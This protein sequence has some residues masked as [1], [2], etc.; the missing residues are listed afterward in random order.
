[1]IY[2]DHVT[3]YRH[4]SL[5]YLDAPRT[6]PQRSAWDIAS[7]LTVTIAGAALV[8]VAVMILGAM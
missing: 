5:A 1:M 8:A 6:Y 7:A 2:P 3:R 4:R